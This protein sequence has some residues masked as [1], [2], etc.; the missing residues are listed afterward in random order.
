MLPH[1]TAASLSSLHSSA[2][3]PGAVPTP[4]TV[5]EEGAT[6][7]RAD[8]TSVLQ[9]SLGADV[10]TLDALR[11]L[12]FPQDGVEGEGDLEEG[13]EA[14]AALDGLCAAIAKHDARNVDSHTVFATG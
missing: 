2:D 8:L 7:P 1:R 13:L 6:G 4:G 11:T 12:Y 3:A 5:V 10:A 14:R 9:T